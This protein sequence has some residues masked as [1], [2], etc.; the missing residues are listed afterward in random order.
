MAV[1]VVVAR[2][3]GRDVG[4][5]RTVRDALFLAN[6]DKAQ[7]SW[8]YVA[9]AIA[10]TITGLAYG[11][12]ASRIRRHFLQLTHQMPTSTGSDDI[13]ARSSMVKRSRISRAFF[14]A[15]R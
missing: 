13:A 15:S 11:P 10:V 4:A 9:S 8:M 5:G 14:T 2:S 7:L 12:L 1:G 6:M 3:L